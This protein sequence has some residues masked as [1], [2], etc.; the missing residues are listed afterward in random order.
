MNILR[1]PKGP[2]MSN[3]FLAY[4]GNCVFVIDPSVSPEAVKYDLPPVSAI[5]ITHGHYDHIKYVDEWHKSFPD[6]PIYMRP[7]DDCLLGDPY[8]ICSLT[9]LS[10]ACLRGTLFLRDPSAVLT[11]K[12]ALLSF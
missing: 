4:V 10:H 9:A 8:A 11:W 2:F 5:L 7:E 6:A 3:M 1:I 12:E